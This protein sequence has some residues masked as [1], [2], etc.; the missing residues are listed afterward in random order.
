MAREATDHLRCT[1]ASEDTKM[2]SRIVILLRKLELAQYR[3]GGH[4]K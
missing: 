4:S 2:E 1:Y 3:N